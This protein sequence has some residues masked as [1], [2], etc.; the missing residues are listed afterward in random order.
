MYA[1][2]VRALLK[3]GIIRDHPSTIFLSVGF[4]D[5]GVFACTLRILNHQLQIA[6]HQIIPGR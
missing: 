3:T 4:A 5:R 2:L 6:F 1:F